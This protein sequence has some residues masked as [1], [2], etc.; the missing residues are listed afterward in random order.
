MRK[1]GHNFL[2]LTLY[3]QAKTAKD[4]RDISDTHLA[5]DGGKT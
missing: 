4:L 5:R 2:L 1:G 3:C